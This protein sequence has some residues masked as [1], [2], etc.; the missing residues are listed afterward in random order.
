[1]G[2]YPFTLSSKD[3]VRVE[4]V[5]P[6][7][8]TAHPHELARYQVMHNERKS[9]AFGGMDGDDDDGDDDKKPRE[10]SEG[11]TLLLLDVVSGL[12]D[13]ER[14]KP[15]PGGAAATADLS[16]ATTTRIDWG[17]VAK[18]VPRRT[19]EECLARF[20]TLKMPDPLSSLT[21]PASDD[22]F[23]N[24]H[25][26]HKSGEIS[27]PHWR[28]PLATSTNPIMHLIAAIASAVN[29][30]IAAECAKH[31]LT[32]L[33]TLNHFSGDDDENKRR[34]RELE[35]VEKMV[36]EAAVPMARRL[37]RAEDQELE[38]LVRALAD[39]QLKKLE[40]KMAALKGS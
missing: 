13:V 23:N 32:H 11:E 28:S 3:F 35:I 4:A 14:E 19:R 34:E 40:L 30:G 26:N 18:H 2:R 9:N 10:W 25:D 6:H 20:L 21:P 15:D 27:D 24:N 12:V 16:T 37:A 8:T 22:S 5:I 38:I 31:A 36:K 1:M 33:A 29:P 17:K 39:A 7:P